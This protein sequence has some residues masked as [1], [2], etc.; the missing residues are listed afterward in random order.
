[1]L[2]LARHLPAATL[3]R[4]HRFSTV[5]PLPPAPAS[6]PAPAPA[7]D[8][9]GVRVFTLI[10]DHPWRFFG[11]LLGALV[12]YLGRSMIGGSNQDALASA[13]DATSPLH[14]RADRR[15]PPP[16]QLAA[17]SRASSARPV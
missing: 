10:A 17:R 4:S 12:A 14:P 3:R 9:W 15:A 1:M 7:A 16:S 11:P 5:P 8:G 6:P 2:R 13:L